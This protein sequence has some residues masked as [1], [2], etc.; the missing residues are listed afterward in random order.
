MTHS[1]LIPVD[2][3]FTLDSVKWEALPFLL[4]SAV[5]IRIQQLRLAVNTLHSCVGGAVAHLSHCPFPTDSADDLKSH[6]ASTMS[7]V[8]T[9][10]KLSVIS[11]TMACWQKLVMTSDRALLLTSGF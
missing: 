1:L 5:T 11:M 7:K 9:C 6:V 4:L 10:S 2:F 3:I 8:C